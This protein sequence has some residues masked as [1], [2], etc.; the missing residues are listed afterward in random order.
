M[1][2]EIRDQ[3]VDVVEK[4]S[5]KTG[6]DVGQMIEWL[7]IGTSK[8]YDWKQRYGQENH[9]NAPTP[10]PFWLEDWEKEEIIAFYVEHPDE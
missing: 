7:G 6:M 8:Y 3:V 9:H 10:R 1:P 4:W 2:R 5:E